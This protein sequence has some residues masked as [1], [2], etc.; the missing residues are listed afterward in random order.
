M[1]VKYKGVGWNRQKRIY[2]ATLAAFVV[3]CLALFIFATILT[4][5]NATAETLII[6]SAAWTAM[7]LLHLILCIGPLARL[8]AR[9][10]PLLYNRRHLGV[11][12]FF[13]ALVHAALATFQFHALGKVNPIVSVLTA[14]RADYDP[15]TG[16]AQSLAQFPFEPFGALA[17]V[18]LFFMVATS[19]DFWLR[20]LGA[21]F[22]K[23]MHMLV[24]VAYGSLI[25][26][27]SFGAL[28][29]EHNP[30]YVACVALGAF[31]VVGLHVI[32]YRKEV[33]TD[34]AK[35]TAEHDGYLFAYRADKIAE[36]RGKAVRVGN[37]RLALF[38]HEDRIFAMSN[39]CRHQGG[40]VG[41]GRILDG[42]VTCPW[43]GWQYKPEDGCSPPPFAEII[44]TYRV[45]I[46]DGDIYVHPEANAL[47]TVCNG[48]RVVA[49]SAPGA[50]DEFYIGY[51]K[52]APSGLARY[53]RTVVASLTLIVPLLTAIVAVAQ[54]PFDRGR[55]EFGVARQ[56]EGEL[57]EQPLPL[58]R[59]KNPAGSASSFPLVG[60][61]KS[62]L[63]DF[64]RGYSGS[65]VRF[66]GSLIVHEGI[67]MIEVNDAKSF[68]IAE[69]SG[70]AANDARALDLGR[71]R[72]VGELVDTKCYFGVMRPA[73]GKVHRACAVRCLEGGVP[74]GLLLR[75]PDGSSQVVLLAGQEGEPLQF[76][77]QWAALT[78]SAE[79]QLE[80]HDEVPV[81]RTN[82]L[83]IH[84]GGASGP[85]PN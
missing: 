24:Y 29:S 13:L 27:V 67:A 60:A 58:L 51:L 40:P 15:F 38:R 68:E 12:M 18:I 73:T 11:T 41:E 54:D 55:F 32:A 7:L 44:P 62:G 34:R 74:P 75:L 49:A 25:V 53:A 80:L 48:A 35:Q 46:I 72:L 61:G 59:V 42:C 16:P 4:N 43:H 6:R 17:L 20:N 83:A 33:H 14:Y 52:K 3:A 81:L 30:V 84:A 78:V 10:L 5:P 19:H 26:H 39:V 82:A 66:K 1:S 76:D 56:F 47:K 69:K 31:V 71:V 23:L 21:S 22:W 8:D 9:F 64:A 45:K 37:E 57:F 79:G 50:Q 85:L 28:Q 36:G 77:P 65:R 2:D 63:P 70:S